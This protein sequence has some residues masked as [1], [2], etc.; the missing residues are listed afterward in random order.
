MA[1]RLPPKAFFLVA[2]AVALYRHSARVA[3]HVQRLAEALCLPP[4]EIDRLRRVGRLHDVG[5]LGVDPRILAKPAALDAEEWEAVK[6]HP[7][8][9]SRLLRRFRISPTEALAVECH[10]ERYDGAGYYGVHEREIPLAAHFLI[11]ADSYDAMTSDRPYRGALSHEDALDEIERN[12]GSQF[13]PTVAKAFVAL[14]RDRDPL[15]ELSPTERAD[16]AEALAPPEVELRPAH[17]VR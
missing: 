16:L 1:T 2:G 10:H 6:R 3:D 14:Q 4:H 7:R 15:M 11:V 13:H 8:L 17:A 12:V 9:S 5:K